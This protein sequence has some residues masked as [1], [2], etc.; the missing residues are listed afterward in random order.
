MPKNF[1]LDFLEIL[2][3]KTQLLYMRKHRTTEI[4]N[5]NIIKFHPHNLEM[6]IMKKYNNLLKL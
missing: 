1:F 4:V 5:E 2:A 6:E 3:R